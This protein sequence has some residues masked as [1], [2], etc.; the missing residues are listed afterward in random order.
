MEQNEM[1]FNLVV[2]ASLTVKTDEFDDVGLFPGL[3]GE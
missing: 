2:T 1:T 3:M